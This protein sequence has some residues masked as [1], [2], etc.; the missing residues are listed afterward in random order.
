MHLKRID[1]H[2]HTVSTEIDEA[3]DFSIEALAEHVSANSLDAIAVTNH[4][5][6]DKANFVEV[7]EG[8]PETIVLP[9]VEVS[10]E[11]FHVLVIGS[12]EYVE[13]LSEKCEQL[14][15][16][17]QG[18]EGIELE[19]FVELFCDGTFLAIPHYKKNPHIPEETL[20]KLG[21]AVSALE[22]TSQKKW[23]RAF[24]SQGKPVVV[25]SDYRASEAS[26]SIIGKYT[27]TSI[28]DCSFEA[29]RL[30]FL[31]K[32][33]FQL[34]GQ[35]GLLEI[36]PN[37][38]ASSKLNVVLGARSSGKT[39]LLDQIYH[40]Q[41]PDDVLYI[42]QF[43]IVK[44]A[45]ETEFSQLLKDEA[46]RFESSYRRELV[47]L[48]QFVETLPSRESTLKL[49]KDY[50]KKL[51][52]YAETVSREDAFSKCV[53]YSA[54]KL[55]VISS[56]DE[57]KLVR[58][59]ITLM[60][61]NVLSEQIESIVGHEQLR[62]LLKLAIGAFKSAE[63]LKVRRAKTNEIIT[64]I[65]S[66]LAT[67]SSRPQCPVSPFAETCLRN[68]VVNRLSDFRQNMT[69]PQLVSE[70]QVG[71]FKRVAKRVNHKDATKLKHAIGSQ[72]SLAGLLAKESSEFVEKV[73]ANAAPGKL[74]NAFFDIEVSLLNE[75]GDS[76]SGGQKA[77]YLFLRKIEDAETFDVVLIDEPE[78]SFDNPFL[79][80]EIR[81][82]VKRISNDTTVFLSTHNNILGVSVK[83]DRIILATVSKDGIHDMYSGDASSAKLTSAAGKTIDRADT[84]L[85]LMEAGQEAYTERQPYYGLDLH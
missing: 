7:R 54:S 49:T 76:V 30:A 34:S 35:D 58:A 25:F 63:L 13:T 50:L 23:Q 72:E 79:F 42:K 26:E 70:T 48:C 31:D 16:I 77:E 2:I 9:G 41:A 37:L 6:F 11:K 12:P 38:C 53:M 19:R 71:R 81:S 43:E 20:R 14:P 51:K 55:A 56:A 61:K 29:L 21:N 17:R 3:F 83:P 40:S 62:T 67:K 65:K 28:E 44:D 8:L 32:A 73:I 36:A 33:K 52:E 24:E 82:H 75:V 60:D 84:L 59:V 27:C 74:A 57:E 47:E 46:S 18:D 68:E 69:L 5:I 80:E 15:H 22:V 4:N 85:D 1:L 45:E 78:S 66:A 39:Y 10:V 64:K